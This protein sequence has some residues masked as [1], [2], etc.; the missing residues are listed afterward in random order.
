[1]ITS[2]WST[3][4]QKI[5]VLPAA[6]KKQTFI[7]TKINHFL[8]AKFGPRQSSNVSGIIKHGFVDKETYD[9]VHK[10]G[11]TRETVMRVIYRIILL[12]QATCSKIGSTM[13]VI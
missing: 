9:I 7:F 10:G 12:L 5:R 1:M 11:P 3:H 2:W 8:L 13:V 4:G 6:G